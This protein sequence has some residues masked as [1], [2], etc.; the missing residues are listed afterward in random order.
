MQ[1]PFI[2]GSEYAVRP[3]GAMVRVAESNGLG[4]V[5]LL[6][7]H[8]TDQEMRP[9]QRAERQHEV[10][11]VNNRLIPTLGP[12][13]QKT[14]RPRQFDPMPQLAR[15]RLAAEGAAAQVERHGKSVARQG[16]EQG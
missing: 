13:N 5:Q 12:A 15:Q 16:T 4:T 10:G 1:A 2:R 14:D 9:G 8:G 3:A 11:E 6:R 7:Q